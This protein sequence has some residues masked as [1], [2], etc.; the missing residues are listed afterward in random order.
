[1]Y[2]IIID[3][4]YGGMRIG[5]D[6]VLLFLFVLFLLLLVNCFKNHF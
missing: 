2:T 4:H 6:E 3:T 5:C 1:M